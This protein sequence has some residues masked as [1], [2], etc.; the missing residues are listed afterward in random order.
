V[1]SQGWPYFNAA[2]DP[3]DPAASPT[4]A[5][6]STQPGRY[7][8]D[9]ARTWFL[10]GCHLVAHT[11]SAAHDDALAA[12]VGEVVLHFSSAYKE[13]FFLRTAA[14]PPGRTDY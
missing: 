8:A 2:H 12:A 10:A 4:A 9:R 14:L 13:R 7:K 3:A 1:D 5:G 6:T 11:W